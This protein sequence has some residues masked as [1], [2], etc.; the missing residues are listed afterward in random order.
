MEILD[1]TTH[2]ETIDPSFDPLYRLSLAIEFRNLY[3]DHGLCRIRCGVRDIPSIS[4]FGPL[5]V[6]V[7]ET[8]ASQSNLAGSF[9]Y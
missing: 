9:F 4:S 6:R 8:S 2:Y 7:V 3:K 1:G 5:V